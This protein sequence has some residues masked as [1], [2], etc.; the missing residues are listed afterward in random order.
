MSQ[1]THNKVTVTIDGVKKQIGAG[2]TSMKELIAEAGLNAKTVS[3]TV[4]SA[5]PAQAST[6]GANDSYYF[7][8]GEVL[9]TLKLGV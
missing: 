9:T 2:T 3:L 5:A 8:G 7:S 1:F 6:I 4:N